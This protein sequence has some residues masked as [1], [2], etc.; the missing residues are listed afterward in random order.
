MQ[1]FQEGCITA[2][3]PVR[4]ATAY[5]QATTGGQSLAPLYGRRQF[6]ELAEPENL[7]P[8]R[9]NPD[10]ILWLQSLAHNLHSKNEESTAMSS[11]PLKNSEPTAFS[12]PLSIERR[13]KVRF[14]LNL[15]VTYRTLS[16][17]ST[18][19]GE[20]WVVNMNRSGVLVSIEHE[21]SVG[22]RVELSIE[23]PSLL[24]GRVPLRF[25]TAGEV[26]RCDASSF[27][28]TLVRYQF[29]TAKRKV[30]AIDAPGS[31]RR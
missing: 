12:H 17:G 30:T 6:K 31:D 7:Q 11:N 2:N 13:S 26:V 3:F 20:G 15:R 14:P 19:Y 21:I 8:P 16:R 29:R 18:S 22:A 1:I 5:R 25:V 24:H 4:L 10:R 28:V 27:A 9:W 23:W